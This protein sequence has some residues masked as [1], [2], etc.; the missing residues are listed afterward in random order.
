MLILLTVGSFAN[1]GYGFFGFHSKNNAHEAKETEKED[2]NKRKKRR[3]PNESDASS[4][5][6]VDS[7]THL[8]NIGEDEAESS[9][10]AHSISAEHKE[11]KLSQIKAVLKAPFKKGKTFTQTRC[12][13]SSKKA[14]QPVLTQEQVL[15]ELKRLNVNVR[16]TNQEGNLIYAPEKEKPS[17]VSWLLKHSR[18]F[19]WGIETKISQRFSDPSRSLQ[20]YWYHKQFHQTSPHISEDRADTMREENL[21]HSAQNSSDAFVKPKSSEANRLEDKTAED[22]E[23]TCAS[24]EKELNQE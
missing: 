13:R 8:R 14:F 19:G 18:A 11:S 9:V 12:N 22:R 23:H 16:I 5:H 10:P 1:L 15:L 21:K 20:G 17:M 2:I 3:V 24:E 4:R 6:V 7:E